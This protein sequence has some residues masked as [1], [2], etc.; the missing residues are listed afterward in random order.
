MISQLQL[1][2]ARGA[3]A[4][5]LRRANLGVTEAEMEK[6]EVADFGLSDLQREGAQI[7]TWVQTDRI[8]VKLIALQPWQALPEHWHP[9]V[10]EDPGKEETIRVVWGTLILGVDGPDTVAAA[11]LPRG[12][13]QYYTRRQEHVLRPGK[14]MQFVPGAAH[15][16]QG[17]PEGTVLFSF[18]TVARDV[19]D[20]FTDP[21]VQRVTVVSDD[22]E[23]R[24]N[25]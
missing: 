24:R 6:I 15:W 5:L 17:G 9:P 10:G 20:Q 14:Q 13:E 2:E 21:G 19:L 18:S 23:A 11:R 7:L 22:A 1:A 3:A 12:K 8:G 16:F 4:S 25:R